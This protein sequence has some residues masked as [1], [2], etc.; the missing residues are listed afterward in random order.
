PYSR[1]A[2]DAVQRSLRTCFE[3]IDVCMTQQKKPSPFSGERK[4][5]PALGYHWLTPFYDGVAALAGG[6]DDY[7]NAL[8][9]CA[10]FARSDRILDVASGTGSLAIAIKQRFPTAQVDALDCDAAMLSRAAHKAGRQKMNVHFVR[11]YAQY[12]PYADACFDHVVSS[13]FFHHLDWNGKLHV[14]REMFRVLKPGGVLHVLDWGRAGNRMMRGLF[15]MV[16]LVDGFATTRDNVSGRLVALFEQA[17]FSG[18]RQL[19]SFNT[20]FGTLALY[21]A[22]KSGAPSR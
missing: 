16:Q 3:I 19:Q 22:G 21:G 8:I 9:D 10:A 4:Y 20:L 1:T 12:L 15:Y 7:L 14:A 5:I 18:V 17:G 11:A 13:L 6:G 2:H